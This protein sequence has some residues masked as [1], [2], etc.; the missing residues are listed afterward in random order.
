MGGLFTHS[1]H[2]GENGNNMD[3]GVC[4]CVCVKRAYLYKSL[5]GLPDLCP[6][7]KRRTVWSL[8]HSESLLPTVLWTD[9]SQAVCLQEGVVCGYTIHT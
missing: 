4:V 7:F 3:L 5:P 1:G 6:F 2:A 8:S 9:Q